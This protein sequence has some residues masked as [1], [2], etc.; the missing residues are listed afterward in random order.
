MSW[1]NAGAF[2][3]IFGKLYIEKIRIKTVNLLYFVD[4]SSYLQIT[5]IFFVNC[6]YYKLCILLVQS[7]LSRP[8]VIKFTSCLP[9]VGGSLRVLPASSTTNTGRQHVHSRMENSKRCHVVAAI[10]DFHSS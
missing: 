8:Q 1:S 9:M 10:L 7:D 3:R 5:S 4:R 2:F 6:Y